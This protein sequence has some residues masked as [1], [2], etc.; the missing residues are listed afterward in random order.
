MQRRVSLLAVAL[1][2]FGVGEA[3]LAHAD[4]DVKYVGEPQRA[5]SK[6]R[7]DAER[8]LAAGRYESALALYRLAIKRDTSDRVAFRDGGR[9]A[10]ALGNHAVA[11]EMLAHAVAMGPA[12]EAEILYLLGEA[13]WVLGAHRAAEA[14][15]RRTLTVLGR[16]PMQRIEKLWAA[17]VHFRLGD[18]AAA[19]AIYESL[20]AAD[21]A[22][23]E[24]AL[25]R[26]EMHAGVRDWAAAE[27]AIRGLLPH[28]PTNKRA[29]EM[30]AWIYEARG[31]LDDEIALRKT[32]VGPDA[33]AD[34]VRDYGRA[35]ER[36]GDW[37]AALAAYRR[38]ADLPN[39]AADVELRR[40]LERVERRMSL[41]IV[42]GAIGRS[43]PNATALGGFAGVALPFGRASHLALTSTHEYVSSGTGD[44]LSNE[45]RAAAVLRRSDALAILGAKAGIIDGGTA[46][47]TMMETSA[48]FAPAAFANL[49]SGLLGGHVTLA[50]DGEFG[51]LWRESPSAV[52]EAGRS[53]SAAGHVY[54]SALAQRFVIDSGVQGRQLRLMSE[55]RSPR[56]DQLL[57][58]SGADALVWTNFANQARGEILDED[59]HRATFA[60]DSA[61]ISYRHYEMFGAVE[62]M[63]AS[64]LNLSDRASIDEV[65]G[66]LRKVLARGALALE[67]RGGFG[68][69]WSRELWLQRGSLAVWFSP[70]SRSRLSLAFELARESVNALVGERRTGMV[71]YHVDL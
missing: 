68:R 15:H 14:T 22:D 44:V 12:P 64:R 57:V 32:L 7:D 56:A 53:Y 67:A 69:D 1:A 10:F 49:S 28:A 71:N 24:A 33:D 52:F 61:V 29:N 19:D 39:G 50:V 37:A 70:G 8:E 20:S 45:V 65:S 51:G 47:S 66:T 42:V 35:L 48:Q 60:A 63:F 11:A 18:R 41:E 34:D 27:R 6:P 62:P 23:A 31:K 55:G 25:A 36:A 43:D 9:A 3:T 2:S 58:W 17:R 59:M 54:I 5:P 30:L 21:P 40:A 38:A 13:Q 46:P 16:S 26:A 4:P